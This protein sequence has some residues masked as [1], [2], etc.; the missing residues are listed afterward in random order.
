[1][2]KN[3]RVCVGMWLLL[4][5][6]VAAYISHSSNW[7][8]FPTTGLFLIGSEFNWARFAFLLSL[9]FSFSLF[10]FS[11]STK[12]MKYG[13]LAQQLLYFQLDIYFMIAYIKT[14]S[15]THTNTIIAAALRCE[16]ESFEIFLRIWRLRCKL[17]NISSS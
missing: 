2:R 1:M 13:V 12:C 11:Q 14:L 3:E 5:L 7:I 10:A 9:S 8:L 4:S 16:K 6:V 17:L 15:R